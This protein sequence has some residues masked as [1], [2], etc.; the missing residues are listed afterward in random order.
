MARMYPSF[1][2]VGLLTLAWPCIASTYHVAQ[3]LNASDTNPGSQA[4][5][6]RTISKAAE[7]A[8][9]GDTV[10]V[11]RGLYR[12]WVNPKNSGTEKSPITYSA[13]EGEDVVVSGADVMT[14]WVK[15]IEDQPVYKVPWTHIFIVGQD[16]GGKP[17]EHHPGD[18]FHKLSGRAEEVFVDGKIVEQVLTR[19]EMKPGTFCADTAGKWLYLWLAD[20]G[21]PNPHAVEA[22][23]RDL[24]FGINPWIRPKGVDYIHV[25]GFIFRYAAN[26][27]QRGAVWLFGEGD[28]VEDCVVEWMS[29]SGI[30]IGGHGA[31]VRRVTARYN[32]HTG[33]GAYGDGFLMEDC[34]ITHNT[35]KAYDRGWDCGG[36]KICLCEGGLIRRCKYLANG[37]TGLWFDIDVRN[38]RVT[39]CEFRDNEGC[40]VFV[41]ISRGV[42]IDHCVATGNGMDEKT[43]GWP[44]G[45]LT[46]AESR[47][48]II[49]DNRCIGNRCGVTMREQGPRA[50]DG[51]HG[52]HVSYHCEN[53]VIRNN[54][55]EN[56]RLYQLGLWMDNGYF[57]RHPAQANLTDEE[58]RKA[59]ETS[60]PFDPREQH[61]VIDENTYKVAEGQ[62]LALVGCPWRKGFKEYLKLADFTRDWGFDAHS[63]AL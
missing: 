34:T 22:A 56:N 44:T 59:L 33:G 52:E 60:P 28:V 26:F 24:I 35:R 14:G 40:G 53:D 41:E 17:I 30:G 12:E 47:D 63:K 49:E 19:A 51:L 21:D 1:T 25:K 42:R 32:G 61:F 55:C 15:D 5:P 23:T 57:G 8:L 54:V 31:I 6:F 9:P 50:F 16:K 3:T 10:L 62:K 27:A 13:A 11:H 7:I 58:W 37:G 36:S 48:C 39:E 2:L 46:L 20:G 18:D 4:L 38:T 45:G 29:G 43:A